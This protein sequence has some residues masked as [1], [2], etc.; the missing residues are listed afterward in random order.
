MNFV[1]LS[2]LLSPIFSGL[3]NIIAFKRQRLFSKVL[4]LLTLLGII[5]L[6]LYLFKGHIGAE[7]QGIQIIG[8]MRIHFKVDGLAMIFMLLASFLWFFT[9]CY[10][11]DYMRGENRETA[12]NG[13][14]MF[15]LT[16]VLGIAMSANLMTLYIFYELLTLTTF[17][18]VIFRGTEESLQLGKKYLVYS[19][20][21]SSMIIA[22]MSLY[23]FQTGLLDFSPLIQFASPYFKLSY[24]LLFLGFGVKAALVP[25]HSWLPSAM[26]APTPVSAL[27]HAVA[28]VKSSVF[29]LIRVT[30]FLFG[31]QFLNVYHEIQVGLL[32]LITISILVGAFLAFHQSNLKKRLAY[33]TI[34]Q[35]GYIMLGIVLSNEVALTGSILHL[36]NHALIKISLFFTVGMMY[37]RAHITDFPEVDGLG[38][39]MPLTFSVFMWSTISI[40][41]LPPSNGFVS[42]WFLAMGAIHQGRILFV[43]V[44]LTSAFMTAIYLLP[45]G[46]NAFFK[47]ETTLHEVEPLSLSVTLPLM[48]ITIANIYLG[49]FPNGVI[50]F[51]EVHVIQNIF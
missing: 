3:I 44:L 24:I 42:K 2:I 46:I 41:G 1:L 14:L 31:Y 22:G 40:M 49:L 4:I 5:G 27:L 32:I 30:Y 17:P 33:S 8:P 48:A 16:P 10:S 6:E 50:R 26:I 47:K 15:V 45:V 43:F 9:A 28:V 37:K 12:F 13:Y 23:F 25:F 11:F 36:I 19:F 34:S 21:G 39:R 35:L 38:K 7:T 29:S 20:V 51:I 18:L